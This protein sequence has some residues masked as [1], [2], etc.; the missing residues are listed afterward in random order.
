[1]HED[2]TQTVGA[3]TRLATW[4]DRP[5]VQRAL[6]RDAADKVS[7]TDRSILERLSRGKCTM[8]Q[9]ARWQGVDP[10]TTTVEVGRLIRQGLVERQRSVRDQRVVV[11]DLTNLGREWA[12]RDR[13]AAE[14]VVTQALQGWT[15]D[16][17]A[18]LADLLGR[19]ADGV[20]AVDVPG[21]TL[22]LDV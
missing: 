1:M 14:A 21:L 15:D 9:L 17:R 5:A 13:A 22:M 3:I 10:S 16:D 8:G 12:A 6:H 2:V 7:R 4:L 20:E 18:Q 19:L 11:V